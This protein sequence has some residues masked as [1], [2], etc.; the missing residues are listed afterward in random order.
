[1]QC[2]A[3]QELLGYLPL[4][5][6]AMGSVLRHG[7]HPS[8]ARRPGQFVS[9]QPSAP[10]GPLQSDREPVETSPR[11]SLRQSWF[12]EALR[13]GRRIGAAELAEWWGISEK[14]ARRDIARLKAMGLIQFL[15]SRRAGRY[16]P[17]I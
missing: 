14:S 12:L 13:A 6:E 16:R 5:L 4:E 3:G 7:F 10:R 11:S 15:G 1:V 8:K 9:A 2:L 17:T